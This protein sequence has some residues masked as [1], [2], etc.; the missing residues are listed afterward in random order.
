MLWPVV[1]SYTVYLLGYY[2]AYADPDF[3]Y[4]YLLLHFFQEDI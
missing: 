1:P 4:R 3:A 2:L